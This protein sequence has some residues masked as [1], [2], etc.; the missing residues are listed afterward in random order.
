MPRKT[1]RRPWGSITEITR[2]KKYVLRWV[3]NTDKGRKRKSRTFYG[4][5]A[6]A[7]KEL[8]RI[9]FE[10]INDT[11]TMTI[12]DVINKWYLPWLMK[13]LEDGKIKQSTYD[14]YL[15]VIRRSVSPKWRNV[16]IDSISPIDVQEWIYSLN[17]HECVIA[18]VIL[19]A[20]MD[21]PTKYEL[22]ETNKFRI[23]YD[24]PRKS[25][26]KQK[27]KLYTLEE[28]DE[29][30]RRVRGT[31][32]EAA[33]ILELFGSA[34]VGESLGVKCTEVKL[35]ER[36]GIK[37]AVVP[38]IRRADSYGGVILPDGDLKTP[39]SLRTVIIPEPYG[40]RLYEIAQENIAYK[41]LTRLVDGR[42]M[43]CWMLRW[44]W[45][46]IAG[47]D[48]ITPSKL[49]NSWRT[50]AQFEWGIDF[51]TCEVLMG[52]QLPGVSGKHYIKPSDEQLIDVVTSAMALRTN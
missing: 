14:A 36:N 5:Y 32:I 2:G 23:N 47:D 34:R 33:I 11:P 27:S 6:E 52:H 41:W 43:G 28:A 50:F 45:P 30:F 10:N 9:R 24:I 40:T 37:A 29:M 19:K 46:Q 17:K 21:F 31:D 51:D 16:P 3:Q 1:R 8:T 48:W 4:T 42:P 35:V 15:D 38:I 18:M 22:V 25:K 20:A 13:R 26:P 12:G 7:D 49:R 44:R 39:H